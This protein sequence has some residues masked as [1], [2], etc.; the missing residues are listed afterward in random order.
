MSSEE[1]INNRNDDG[2]EEVK[3]KTT[4]PNSE[5]VQEVPSFAVMRTYLSD[6]MK[7]TVAKNTGEGY[8]K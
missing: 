4:P 8:K 2:R 6:H 7:G 3:I 1:K 5:I